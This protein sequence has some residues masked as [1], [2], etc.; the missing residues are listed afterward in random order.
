MEGYTE[1][2]V[3]SLSKSMDHPP[4]ASSDSK[5]ADLIAKKKKGRKNEQKKKARED[6]LKSKLEKYSKERVELEQG[7][8]TEK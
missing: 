4:R 7:K 2:T 5:F 1:P 8:P 3:S 6:L